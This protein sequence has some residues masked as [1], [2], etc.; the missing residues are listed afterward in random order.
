[1]MEGR[2]GLRWLTIIFFTNL[3]IVGVT[4][5]YRPV[6]PHGGVGEF[7]NEEKEG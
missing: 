1:M 6:I 3:Y 7:G 5:P 2:N 4:K